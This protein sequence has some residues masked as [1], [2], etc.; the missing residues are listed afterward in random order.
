MRTFRQDEKDMH[1]ERIYPDKEFWFQHVAQVQQLFTVAIL[2][3]LM[4]KF[5]SRTSDQSSTSA[6]NDTCATTT[7]N[8]STSASS[9]TN[10]NGPTYSYCNGPEEGNMVGCD[11]PTCPTNGSILTAWV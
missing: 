8:Q 7:S 5:Y 6:S 4:G 3:E 2:P 1:V 9:D 10:D 11:N